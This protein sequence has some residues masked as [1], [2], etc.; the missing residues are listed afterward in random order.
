MSEK[1]RNHADEIDALI[2]AIEIESEQ[3]HKHTC[4]KPLHEC[5]IC[6]DME[7]HKAHA[8]DYGSLS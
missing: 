8:R 6:D 1:F 3:H 4:A 7:W 2:R 5:P